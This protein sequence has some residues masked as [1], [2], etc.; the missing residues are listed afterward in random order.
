MI[1]HIRVQEIKGLKQCD[2]LDLGKINVFC[3]K[4]NSGKSTILE[5]LN[6]INR[7]FV[8]IR[9]DENIAQ[10][11]F[12]V[13]AN[14]LGLN[15]KDPKLDS[16]KAILNKKL[17]SRDVW[18]SNEIEEFGNTVMEEYCNSY[19]LTR[20]DYLLKSLYGEFRRLFPKVPSITLLPPKRHLELQ[21][22][23]NTSEAIGSEGKGIL[24]F[25]FFAKNQEENTPNKD[26]YYKIG[27]AFRNISSGFSF[28]VFLRS[29]NNLVLRF[30]HKD[31]DWINSVDCG[32]GLQDLLV[33]LYFAIEPKFEILLIEEPENHMHPEMQ[34]KLLAFLKE[35]ASKQFFLSTHSSIFV[36]SAFVDKVFFTFFSDSVQVDDATSVASILNDIGYSVT[37]NLVS[38]LIVLVEGP[39]D[40]PVLEE[41]MIKMGFWGK[42]DIKIWPLGGDIMDQLDLGVFA[43]KYRLVALVDN[44]PGSDRTRRKFNENCIKLGIEVHRLERYS[45]EN[46]FT[47]EAINHA[48][49]SQIPTTLTA[50][51]PSK[52]LE[53]QIGL[54]P[55]KNNRKIAN[56]MALEDIKDTDLYTFLSEIESICKQKVQN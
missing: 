49:G 31:S 48:L 22:E 16:Y 3:G 10:P 34:K 27:D 6:I 55:K 38:D 39:S 14:I 56:A 13:T 12:E 30:K 40:K 19:G 50:I 5:G 33:M 24:N 35:Q 36:N 47:V 46:Y 37:D 51:D 21:K 43:E 45:L 29:A 32:L 20:N 18:F 52:K 4:N 54:N 23:L 53:G 9:S 25:L 28:D 41:F 15:S 26:L 7:R 17:M 44:D 1:N 42:Y 8:G 2:L 11:L